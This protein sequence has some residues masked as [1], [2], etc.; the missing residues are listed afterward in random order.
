MVRSLP[1]QGW[2]VLA[3]THHRLHELVRR[4]VA[5]WQEG[6]VQ[7]I[8]EP[9][10]VRARPDLTDADFA[11]CREQPLLA[12]AATTVP[13]TGWC[14]A[15]MSLRAPL[16]GCGYQG[17]HPDFEQRRHDNSKRRQVALGVFAGVPAG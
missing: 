9:G 14:A 4:T 17:L 2:P 5:A 10:V 1:G 13:G 7:D 8:A 3:R 6:R 12:D 15:A 16:P 11:S